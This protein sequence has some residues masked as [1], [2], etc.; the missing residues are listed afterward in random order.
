MLTQG[1]ALL[2]DTPDP[3]FAPIH[4]TLRPHLVPSLWTTLDEEGAYAALD[5]VRRGGRG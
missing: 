1:F 3:L 5:Y 4:A 2:V